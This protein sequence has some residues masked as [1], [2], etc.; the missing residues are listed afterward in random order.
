M[1]RAS[2]YVIGSGQD[3][4]AVS[5]STFG[6]EER[7]CV[8]D[9]ASTSVS[10]PTVAASLARSSAYTM[11][12]AHHRASSTASGAAMRAVRAVLRSPRRPEPHS[13]GATGTSPTDQP[14]S[15]ASRGGLIAR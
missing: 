5:V 8:Q 9:Q 1:L 6:M 11:G 3:Q 13:N 4:C 2:P 15:T 14:M 10:A 12:T 7:A